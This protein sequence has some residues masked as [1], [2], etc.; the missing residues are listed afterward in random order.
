M[1]RVAYEDILQKQGHPYVSSSDVLYE[2]HE[3]P[4][5][6]LTQEEI[7]E[8]VELYSTAARN[9][10]AQ[11]GFD[12][13]EVHAANGHLPHQ[14]LSDVVNKRTD[15]YGGSLENRSR[16]GL[17]IIDAVTK[18]IGAERTSVRLSPWSSLKGKHLWISSL[19]SK[20]WAN[21]TSKCSRNENG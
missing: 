19:I 2:G 16:F 1:G 13:V 7:S 5:R 10:V 9:A 18:A 12:G 14:F 17:E 3:N 6:P 21:I 20:S 15:N 8:Y 4:P 11:G